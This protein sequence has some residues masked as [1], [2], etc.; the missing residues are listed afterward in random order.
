MG[1]GA[2]KNNYTMVT[3][4]KLTNEHYQK[5][6]RNCSVRLKKG[7]SIASMSS[8]TSLD[9]STSVTEQDLS[10]MTT[11]KKKLKKGKSMAVLSSPSSNDLMNNNKSSNNIKPLKKGQSE[12][13]LSQ[14]ARR[15]SESP[16]LKGVGRGMSQGQLFQTPPSKGNK[17]VMSAR[18][19]WL[20]KEANISSCE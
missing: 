4:A 15:K 11:S 20:V 10:M 2:S 6:E 8:P 3:D 12:R 9:T 17:M 14:N 7:Q 5:V 16:Q 18:L 1:G 19:S 13:V